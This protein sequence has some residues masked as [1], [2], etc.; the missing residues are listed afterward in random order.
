MA[1]RPAMA[2][3][4][5]LLSVTVAHADPVG[6]QASPTGAALR[7]VLITQGNHSPPIYIHPDDDTN[8]VADNTFSNL[9]RSERP[10]AIHCTFADGKRL[11]Y[12]LPSTVNTCT[13]YSR[14][15][16]TLACE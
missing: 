10:V 2:A 12:T 13:L 3:F 9:T 5:T 4:L 15:P 11:D 14:S 16:T 8:D 1:W 7:N 6:C